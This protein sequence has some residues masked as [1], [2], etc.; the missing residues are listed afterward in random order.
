M[1]LLARL[2]RAGELSATEFLVQARQ[3]VDTQITA[4]ELA[5]ELRRA[6]VAWLQSAGLMENWLAIS[7]E[8]ATSRP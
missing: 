2:W 3:G 7:P 5:G 8:T 1:D 6:A 4:T